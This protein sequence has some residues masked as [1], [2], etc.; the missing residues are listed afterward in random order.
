MAEKMSR[1]S[2]RQ[3]MGIINVTPDSF[4]NQG[5]HLDPTVA[6]EAALQMIE[7][8]ATI[9]DIGGESTRPNAEPTSIQQEID[10][11][12]PVI[13]Q[14]RS[15]TSACL[16]ID[17]R[18]TKVMKVAIAAGADLV[19]DVFALQSEG[20]IALLAQAKVPV[21]LMHMQGIPQTMQKDPHYTDVVTD[22]IAFLEHR[23]QCCLEG[24]IRLE[25]ILVDPGFGFGKS[26]E[27]N[28]QMLRSMHDFKTLKVPLVVGM[29]R[30]SMIGKLTGVT[31]CNQ[32]VPGSV[33]A[34]VVAWM[35]GASIVRTHDVAQTIQALSVVEGVLGM[36]G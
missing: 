35:N 34:A 21:C 9:I 24:G 6:V 2:K 10:R 1:F 3:V 28:L 36:K 12:L 16:S 27:H 33:A 19:N 4:A 11:I 14:L 13:E 32:R 7:D 25:N 20:A 26:L 5:E 15:Q 17:T 31:E 23:K 8:G 29:S 30:K 22:V 18:H